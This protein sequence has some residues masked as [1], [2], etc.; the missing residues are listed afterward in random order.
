[1]YTSP[2][3]SSNKSYFGQLKRSTGIGF[4]G[5]IGKERL[6][7]DEDFMC[8]TVRHHA[9]DK[10]YETGHLVPD[11]VSIFLS[12]YNQR[13]RIWFSV[14]ILILAT[15]VIPSFDVLE[16]WKDLDTSLRLSL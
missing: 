5:E 4:G 10:T 7:I 11:Q 15:K 9:V 16:A 12:F 1:M 14:L 2:H 3:A 8:V 13:S 6:W